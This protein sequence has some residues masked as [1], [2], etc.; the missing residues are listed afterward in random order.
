MSDLFSMYPSLLTLLRRASWVAVIAMLL[1]GSQLAYAQ[2]LEVSGRVISVDD[3]QSLPG[4]NVLEVG[5]DNGTS[6]GPKGEYSITVGG[7]DAR[8]VFSYIGFQD[9]TVAVNGR[10][11]INVELRTQAQQMEQ[12]VVTALGIERQQRSLGYATTEVD[13]S[14]LVEATEANPTELLQGKVPGLVVSTNAGGVASS[15]SLNIRGASTLSGDNDPLYIVD[16]IPIISSSIGGG[17]GAVGA[18]AG[19]YGGFDGGTALSIVS[20]ENIQSI[21]VLKGAGAA[22]RDGSRARDGVV[23]I[24]TKSGRGVE[25]EEFGINYNT[26]VTSRKALTGFADYQ[27]QYG[28]GLLGLPPES[29]T[30]ARNIGLSSW[31]APFDGSVEEAVQFDGVSRPYD[32]VVD[33]QGFYRRGL[34]Q[35]HALSLN[36]AYERVSFRL[37]GSY[38]NSESIV[39]SSGYEQ[40]NTTLRGNATFGNLTADANVTYQNEDTNDRTYLNDPAR[41]PNFLISFLPGNVPKSAL[42]PGYDEEGMEL[43]F[44]DPFQT[45]PYFAVNKFDADDNRDRILGGVQLTYDFLD[46]LSLQ[47]RQGLDWSNLR[48]TTVDPFG[49]GFKPEGSM[50]EREYQR[51]E[52]NTKLLL[53]GTPSLT[54]DLSVRVDMGGNLRMNQFELVGLRG[55]GFNVQGLETISNTGSPERIYSFSEQEV[56]SVFGSAAFSYDD[57]A[58]LTVT[59]RNDWSST[60]PEQNNS[61]FYP[62]VSGSFVFTDVLPMPDWMNFGKVRASWAEIGGDTDPYQ[63][64]LT[65]SLIGE[66]QGQPLGNISGVQVP[67]FNLVPTETRETEVGFETQFFDDRLGLDVTYYRRNTNNQITS[68]SVSEGSGYQSRIL[69]SGKVQNQ[70]MELLLTTTPVQTEDVQWDADFNFAANDSEIESLAQELRT[71]AVSSGGTVSIVQKVGEPVS[72]IYGTPYVRDGEGN[73]VH[74]QDG[75]PLQGEPRVLGKGAPDWTAGFSNM[76]SFKNLYVNVLFDIRWGGQLYSGTNAQAYAYGLH[77]NTLEGRAACEEVK[78]PEEGYPTGGC[79]VPEGVIA[80]YDEEGNLVRDDEGNPVVA[81]ENDVAVLPSEYYGNISGAIAEEF[82]Y[83]ANY[84]NLR[85]VRVGYQLPDRWIGQTPLESVTV[86]LVGRNLF[87]LYDSVPNV[88]P[89]AEY[90]SATTPGIEYASIP[91]TRNIGLDLRVTL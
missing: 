65:Y 7:P 61:Y 29:Q 32:D 69:N 42:R 10:S 15:S 84:I 11:T 28:Q 14:E 34:S 79:F 48:R 22:A 56:R 37:S 57:F 40:L 49:T 35:K 24:N 12:V 43:Q 66:H 16:G 47:G 38:L 27:S 72:A 18:S 5:T 76:V 70:G 26:T 1:G 58:F 36:G 55:Q 86:S 46:W 41:N 30:A 33:R 51:W 59:A 21:S 64:Y 13:A 88:N 77:K 31:G 67:N 60:L 50:E 62:S 83:D 53:T 4:V 25:G 81:G 68:L 39:P 71:D 78:D 63:L 17:A 3:G 23:I 74:G 75:L 80:Q 54:D 9:T 2:E 89:G 45:N 8:L 91:Q 85:Q 6:T 52:S 87:Y 44:S 20:T 73:I 82:I 19:R 90:N